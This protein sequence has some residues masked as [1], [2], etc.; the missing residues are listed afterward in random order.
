MKL[1]KHL[2]STLLIGLIL[3]GL[4]GSYYVSSKHERPTIFISKQESGFNIDDS[5][6][7][8]FSLGQKRFMSSIVWIMTILESDN[9]HY[10]ND[11]LNSWMFHRFNTISILEPLF[12][13]NYAFGGPYLSI[14]KDDIKGATF[15]YNKGL[16]EYPDDFYLL[17]NAAFHF[18]FEVEDYQRSREIHQRLMNHKSINPILYSSLARIESEMGNKEAAFAIMLSNYNDL[19]EKNQT[20]LAEK[21]REHLYAI[22]TEIDL[23]C[24]NSKTSSKSDCHVTDLDGDP[25]LKDKQGL[26]FASKKWVPFKIK[27]YR[28]SK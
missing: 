23:N 2:N 1:S 27:K 5:F 11:D 12:Y 8:F 7:K 3:C 26:F 9:D 21:T 17:K 4:C 25:Y 19:K 14:I 13:E 24:L 20:P 16:S 28:H 15:I 18:H 22:R 10:K 6:F